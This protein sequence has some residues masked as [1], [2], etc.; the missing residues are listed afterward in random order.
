MRL[1]EARNPKIA[2]ENDFDFR[3]ELDYGLL[4]YF[5]GKAGRDSCVALNSI[6]KPDTIYRQRHFVQQRACQVPMVCSLLKGRQKK[7]FPLERGL[8]GYR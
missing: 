5:A 6:N 8:G 1:E 7:K 3:T 4:G 2:V